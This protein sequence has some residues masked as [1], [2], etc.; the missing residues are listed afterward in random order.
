MHERDGCLISKTERVHR[1]VGSLDLNPFF[2]LNLYQLLSNWL[3]D[4][5]DLYPKLDKVLKSSFARPYAMGNKD[6]NRECAPER[7]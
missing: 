5:K 2:S 6:T 7:E 3:M 1:G 4:Y